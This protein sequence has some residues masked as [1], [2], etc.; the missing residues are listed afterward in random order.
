M[1]KVLGNWLAWLALRVYGEGCSDALADAVE[2]TPEFEALV[3][4]PEYEA[5]V[6]AAS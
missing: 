3:A 1:R 2:S 4:T 6:K 5:L